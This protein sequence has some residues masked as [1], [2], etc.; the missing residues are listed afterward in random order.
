MH[1][2]VHLHER[3]FATYMPVGKYCDLAANAERYM[4]T[5]EC[6]DWNRSIMHRTVFKRM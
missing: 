1:R 2:Y 6:Q 5:M 4:C 3:R